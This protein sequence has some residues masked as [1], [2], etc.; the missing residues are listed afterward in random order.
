[1][2][3][4]EDANNEEAYV[5]DE[6]QVMNEPNDGPSNGNGGY[7]QGNFV[8][9]YNQQE[10]SLYY[11]R[12]LIISIYILVLD[13]YINGLV[14]YLGNPWI[15]LLTAIFVYYLIKRLNLN[16][17]YYEW[18]Q[19]REYLAEAEHVKKNPDFYRQRMEAMERARQKQQ[20]NIFTYG[21]HISIFIVR[22]NMYIAFQYK[23]LHI[24]HMLV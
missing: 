5:E 13:S 7:I 11:Y 23:F 2:D 19:K 9:D 21:D 4:V 15:W 17:K 16:T 20:V 8:R 1:M 18:Q 12:L 14:A 3:S 10:Q 6:P 24:S 22:I